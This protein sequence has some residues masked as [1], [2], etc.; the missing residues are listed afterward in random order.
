MKLRSSRVLC[1]LRRGELAT[2]LKI[3]LGDPRVI[4]L[5]GGSGADAVWLCTEHVPTD[6]S[7]LENQIRAARV[8]DMDTLVR[9]ARGSYS[10]YIRPLEADATG[11]I[12]PH[13]ASVAD[14]RQ[15]V[16]WVRYHPLGKRALDGGNIDGQFCQVPL[17]DYLHH[18]NTERILILQIESPEALEHVEA[19]AAV[20]GFDMLLFGPGDFSHRIGKPG[21]LDATEVVAARKR[22]AAA[23]RRNGKYAMTAGLIAPF[24]ELVEEGH[25]AFNLGADVIGLSAY[26]RERIEGFRS[27]RYGSIHDRDGLNTSHRPQ[28]DT[29][30]P[31]RA[32]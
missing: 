11:I 17:P 32:R 5:A 7:M 10:D 4:E 27:L 8:H 24:E 21:Q 9:V 15:I 18:S 19:I 6:W 31:F 25:N 14:A 16:E 13:V 2:V 12:V 1:A 23:A 3:N 29:S 26:F 28:P 22:V 20:P 30:G